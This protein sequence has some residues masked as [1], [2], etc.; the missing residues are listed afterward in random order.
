MR[1]RDYNLA[2]ELPRNSRGE[3]IDLDG[4]VITKERV[5]KYYSLCVKIAWKVWPAGY[6]YNQTATIEDIAN[7]LCGEEVLYVLSKFSARKAM[8]QIGKTKRGKNSGLSDDE[9]LKLKVANRNNKEAI[10]KQ[11]YYWVSRGVYGAA[12]RMRDKYS[13]DKLHGM[14]I[15][16]P[17]H[18]DRI[19]LED[20]YLDEDDNNGSSFG[21]ERREAS[22]STRMTTEESQELVDINQAE[23]DYEHLTELAKKRRFAEI[24]AYKGQM[25]PE[26]QANFRKYL[27]N[28]SSGNDSAEMFAERADQEE[29]NFKSKK[30][31]A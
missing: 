3:F 9:W 22:I 25:S 24:E 23:E 18:G 12:T 13:D 14:T 26:R 4:D 11:E 1:N 29:A 27:L 17:T 7:H 20:C 5:W 15:S 10:E 19:A 2:E 31:Q 21:F 16:V 28:R 30:D 8:T 6:F